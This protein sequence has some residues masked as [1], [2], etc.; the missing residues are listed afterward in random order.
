MSIPTAAAI[1]VS[2]AGIWFGAIA[3]IIAHIA[4]AKDAKAD[5]KALHSIVASL[6]R[7]SAALEE[8]LRRTAPPSSPSSQSG[9]GPEPGPAE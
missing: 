5:R 3:M 6:D 1:L 9:P 8:I 7:Q 2:A 4:R